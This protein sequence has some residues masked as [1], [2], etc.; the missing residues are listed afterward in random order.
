[1]DNLNWLKLKLLDD[2]FDWENS[3][4]TDIVDF[5]NKYS[6]HD[7][8]WIGAF[9]YPRDYSTNLIIE[10]DT[11][12]LSRET[13]NKGGSCYRERWPILMIKI[14]SPISIK[15]INKDSSDEDIMSVS[16]KVLSKQELGYYNLNGDFIET[17]IEECYGGDMSLI[18][19]KEIN[20][21][22]FDRNGNIIINQ[23]GDIDNII[24]N[25]LVEPKS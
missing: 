16:T 25:K 14:P 21:L 24:L 1:M 4:K 20:V 9:I 6:L 5:C 23:K 19:T 17:I 13:V 8:R 7:S 11:C 3:W 18:H 15:C 10:L 22:I 12:S 2:D